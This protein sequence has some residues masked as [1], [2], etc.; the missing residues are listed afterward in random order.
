MPRRKGNTPEPALRE[1][2]LRLPPALAAEAARRTAAG[3]TPPP[4]AAA[5]PA[6]SEGPLAAA[7]RAGAVGSIPAD[8]PADAGPA[9]AVDVNSPEAVAGREDT[10]RKAVALDSGSL[11]SSMTESRRD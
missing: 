4:P 9:D 1:G 7:A 8:D 3:D 2:G 6:Y 5:A 11:Q 10:G